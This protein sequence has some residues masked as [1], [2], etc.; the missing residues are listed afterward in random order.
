M[1]FPKG[2]FKYLQT[3]DT[4]INEAISDAEKIRL[5]KTYILPTTTKPFTKSSSKKSNKDDKDKWKAP[6]TDQDY[7]F[8]LEFIIY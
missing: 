2:M 5:Y 8:V 6:E 3:I 4:F 1:N 7:M